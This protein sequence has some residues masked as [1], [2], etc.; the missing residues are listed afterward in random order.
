MKYYPRLKI[1]KS[2]GGKNT[3]DP[4][5]GEARSYR[6]WTYAV[7]IKG[8]IVFNG[9]SY[10]HT[11]SR[12]QQACLSL[13]HKLNKKV[14]LYVSM[15]DSLSQFENCALKYIYKEI[16]NLEIAIKRKNSRKIKNI[17]RLSRIKALRSDIVLARSLGATIPQGAIRLL[18]VAAI[19]IETARIDLFRAAQQQLAL[20]KAN[21]RLDEMLRGNSEGLCA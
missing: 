1:Y 13:F 17:E 4:V 18:K 2:G 12:H 14:S 8:K 21:K 15:P 5:T 20:Q 7:C 10:S 3:Y 19:E 9:Y 11:T 16:F 6:H